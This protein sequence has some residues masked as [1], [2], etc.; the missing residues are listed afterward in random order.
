MTAVSGNSEKPFA[1]TELSIGGRSLKMK[2]APSRA[3]TARV[4]RPSVATAVWEK[5][6]SAVIS[7]PRSASVSTVASR[8]R[9]LVFCIATRGGENREQVESTTHLRGEDERLL[10]SLVQDSKQLA[11]GT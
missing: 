6:R 2:S 9:K 10:V 1:A 7:G 3:P 8:R 4:R 11:V 5:S